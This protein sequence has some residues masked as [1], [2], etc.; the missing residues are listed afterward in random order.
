M[1]YLQAINDLR[2]A[3]DHLKREPYLFI[4]KPNEENLKNLKSHRID[5]IDEII[6]KLDRTLRPQGIE[7]Y[8]STS[9]EGLASGIYE[10]DKAVA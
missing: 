2:T 6:D 4:L 3:S 9:L 10:W 8:S 7:L 5:Q 1:D